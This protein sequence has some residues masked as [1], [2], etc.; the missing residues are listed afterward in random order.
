MTLI[1]QFI[2]RF[3]EVY[4]P[5]SLAVFELMLRGKQSEQAMLEE[6]EQLVNQGFIV[7]AEA[8]KVGA[9]RSIPSLA[10]K[11]QVL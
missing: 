11:G 7:T 2:Y 4:G 6:I 1:G 3:L 5:T 9:K 10:L 8:R